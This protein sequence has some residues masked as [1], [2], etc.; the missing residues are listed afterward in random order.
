M[1]LNWLQSA[2]MGFV[3]GLSEPLPLSGDANRGLLRQ[4]FGVESEGPLFVLAY[5]VAVLV[6]VLMTGR[7]ELGRLRRTAKIL[8]TPPRRRTGHPDQNSAGTIKLL[9]SAG[10][11]AVVGRLLSVHLDFFAD[12]LYLLT[13]ALVVGGI[14]EWL[15][16]HF[17]S[18][19]KDGRHLAP[20]DGMLMGLGAALSA[21]PGISLV[22]ASASLG[23]LRGT[24]RRYALRFSW[25]LLVVSL[26]AAIFID[27]LTVVGAGFSF[28]WMELLCAAIGGACAAVGAYLAVQLMLALVRRS[29]NGVSSF[30]YYNWGLALLC[31][32]LFL[33]V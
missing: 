13:A 30:C 33:L 20:A 3:S 23:L 8:K 32:V 17:R 26:A 12:K 6:V 24:D 9:R 28:E 5:H 10:L 22:G 31:L 7:L 14:I 15:P 25:L 19:N 11:I 29:S 21:V 16:V 4:L 2:I 1:N 27:V 18:A